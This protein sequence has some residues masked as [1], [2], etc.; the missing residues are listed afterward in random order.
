[1]KNI[2][3]VILVSTFGLLSVNSFG[4]FGVKAGLGVSSWS[5]KDRDVNASKE[6]FNAGFAV[7][8]GFGFEIGF[9]DMVSVE[10]ALLFSQKSFSADL[11]EFFKI[12]TNF[13]EMPVNVKVYLVELGNSAKLYALGGGYV[14]YMFSA[15]SNGEKRDIGNKDGDLFKTL[16]GGINIGVGA[17]LFD[18]LN[19]DIT[20]G[21]GIANLAN[22]QSNGTASKINV[23]RLTVTYQFG[24]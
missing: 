13:V 7:Q 24:G 14:S 9:G 19:A 10:P 16:D 12:K 1:M 11:G 4:Q 18:S 23:V 20:G 6:L 5:L 8:A 21:I 17:K 3:K 15:K 2:V 22:D